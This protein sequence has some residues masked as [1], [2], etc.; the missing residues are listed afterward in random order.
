MKK[1]GIK[2]V[3]EGTRERESKAACGQESERASEQ[4]SEYMSERARVEVDCLLIAGLLVIAAMR[5]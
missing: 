2:R 3:R 4:E 5:H 1:R